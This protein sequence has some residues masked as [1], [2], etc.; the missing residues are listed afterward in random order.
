MLARTLIAAEGEIQVAHWLCRVRNE[1]V[2]GEPEP[3]DCPEH[4]PDDPIYNDIDG[5]LW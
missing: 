1:R 5:V 2:P 4:Q 3:S